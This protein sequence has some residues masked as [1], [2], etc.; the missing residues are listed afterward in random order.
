MAPVS[1]LVLASSALGLGFLHGLGADHLMAI[2]ALAADRGE[3][4]RRSIVRT[5]AAFAVGHAVLLGVATAV[6]VGL[7][8]MLPAAFE[9]AAERLGGVVLM[10]L[11]ATGVW[12]VLS[13][14]TFGHAHTEADGRMRW[15][16][17]VAPTHH[18]HAHSLV[19]TALGSVFALSSLRALMLLEPFGAS[20]GRLTLPAIMALVV[21]FGVGVVTS[22]SLFGVLFARVWSLRGVG[23]ASRSAT[24]V[25]A[26]G[27]LALGAYW[28]LGH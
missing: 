15:H 8:V 10:G 19:P 16:L 23:A 24:L 14:R 20:A 1:F 28:V 21:L 26:I 7:G 17:H 9:T 18:P 13:G 25:V 27:S 22:M 5:A 11:G 2:A 4:S 6:A 3:R 12:S